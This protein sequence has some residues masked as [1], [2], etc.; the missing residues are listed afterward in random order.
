MFV[1]HLF[2]T[3]FYQNLRVIFSKYLTDEPNTFNSIN[4]YKYIQE[5][6]KAVITSSTL[7]V[8]NLN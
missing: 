7:A 2:K 1:N 5:N 4:I 3:I 8:K 6:L